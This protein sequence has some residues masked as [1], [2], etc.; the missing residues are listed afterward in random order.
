MSSGA[1]GVEPQAIATAA[2]AFEAQVEPIATLAQHLDQIKGSGSTTGKAYS[3]QG[4]A[5]HDAVTSSLEKF[6]RSFSE[7]T[8][9]VSGALSQAGADYTAGDGSGAQTI[10]ASGR[11]V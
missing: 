2:K 4:S 9:W 1:F 11:G 5:Y 8:E 3:A 7:K 6:V 10:S